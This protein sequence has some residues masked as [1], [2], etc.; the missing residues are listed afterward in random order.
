MNA[1]Q[2]RVICCLLAFAS[3]ALFKGV[4]YPSSL[5]APEQI[6]Q[7]LND[8]PKL[9]TGH[10][11]FKFV[12]AETGQTIA[13]QNAAHFFTPAS[14]VKLYTT[15]LALVRLGVNYQFKTV[16]RTSSTWSPG[17]D[18]VPDIE[19]I[20]GGD[21]NLSGRVLP[22][23]ES[24]KDGDPLSAINAIA[25]Q[26]AARGIHRVKGDVVADDTRYPY[27]PYPEGWAFDDGL[28]YYGTAVSAL[29]VN[30]NSVHLRVS[31]TT[32]EDLADVSLSPDLDDF[33]VLNQVITDPSSA[34]HVN[35]R[36]LPGS[37]ELVLSG[38]IGL[39]GPVTEEDLGIDEPAP[40]A[41]RA[42]KNALEARGIAVDGEPR[43]H[44]SELSN[45]ADPLRAPLVETLPTGTELVAVSAPLW[46]A[47]Q[48]VNKVSQNLHAEMLLREVAV[49]TAIPA[50]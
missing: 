41:A 20:G 8:S 22:Y 45:L 13:E 23:A 46:Q 50:L 39:T 40:F 16:V 30:D 18:T 9:Q 1:L 47:I 35:I 43:A 29:A 5:S 6:Q 4:S 31:P 17:E 14:N 38:T 36:R 32:S 28:W 25:D 42:L 15:A 48:V 27:D 49:A 19:M 7:L 24:A 12:D 11:G 33:I 10:I 26:I 37:N 21:P 2:A 3:L 34:N 44:H